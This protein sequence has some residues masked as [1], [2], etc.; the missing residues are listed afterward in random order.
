MLRGRKVANQI[1][2]Q[3]PRGTCHSDEHGDL[4]EAWGITL[5]FA[6]PISPGKAKTAAGCAGRP[7]AIYR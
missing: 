4:L 7:F 3:E 6:P 1:A 2:A 5:D